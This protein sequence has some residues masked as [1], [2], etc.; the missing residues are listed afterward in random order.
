MT[1][2]VRQRCLEPFFTTKGERGT[3]MGLAM[4]Y[5]IVQRHKGTMEIDS[6]VGRGTT[7]IIRL[8]VSS[9]HLPKHTYST[10]DRPTRSLHVLVVEDE[11]AVCEVIAGYLGSD[12]HTVEVAHNGLEAL[13]KFETNR[14]DLI[15]TD[16][17][18]PAMS[19]DHVAAVI[20]Q[21]EPHVPVIMLTGFGDL[22]NSAGE[23][24]FGV[25]LILGK[26]VTIAQLRQAISQVTARSKV[27]Q[28]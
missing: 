28:T 14:F 13:Q 10:T 6:V 8:P 24:P 11:P 16:R 4:V 22:M 25:D 1:E 5:G 18:M 23:R 2:E 21:M 7:V 12:G 20:K 9:G 15:I 19:G 3:G 27:G 26:P 17:A